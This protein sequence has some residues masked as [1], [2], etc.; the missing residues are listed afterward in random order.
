MM[1]YAY[2]YNNVCVYKYSFSVTIYLTLKYKLD[3]T[4]FYA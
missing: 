2:R 1:M 4:L 3:I